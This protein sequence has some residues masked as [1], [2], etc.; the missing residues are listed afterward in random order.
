MQPIGAINVFLILTIHYV[1]NERG[2]RRDTGAERPTLKVDIPRCNSIKNESRL[3]AEAPPARWVGRGGRERARERGSR[4]GR[5]T[6][7]PRYCGG[8]VA[9]VDDD[10]DGERNC[11][12]A[13]AR[14]P[15]QPT[16]MDIAQFSKEGRGPTNNATAMR[17]RRFQK[18]LSLRIG[19]GTW[20]ES[21]R[22]RGRSPSPPLITRHPFRLQSA[23]SVVGL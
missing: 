13:R 6:Y 17:N 16:Q 20:K 21:R 22:E 8:G 18:S 14:P 12:R 9:D 23:G 10:D 3:A 2:T 19:D 1:E 4:R 15:A 7:L 11:R 5:S